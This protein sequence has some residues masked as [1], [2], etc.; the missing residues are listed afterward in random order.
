MFERYMYMC[1]VLVDLS[2]V[3]VQYM[4]V[5]DKNGWLST[6]TIHALITPQGLQDNPKVNAIVL[7]KGPADDTGI[8]VFVFVCACMCACVAT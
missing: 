1:T 7:I 2:N 6:L 8:H 5:K 3:C 4:Y